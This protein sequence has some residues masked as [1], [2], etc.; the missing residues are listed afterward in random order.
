MLKFPKKN[1][2][3]KIRDSGKI[4]SGSVLAFF[5]VI[6][7]KS[8]RSPSWGLSKTTFRIPSGVYFEI[9]QELFR[10]LWRIFFGIT[11]GFPTAIPPRASFENLQGFVLSS[12]VNSGNRPGIPPGNFW[13]NSLMVS[14]KEF[15]KSRWYCELFWWQSEHLGL[16]IW[17]IAI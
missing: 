17:E 10:I 6:F 5:F 3:Y 7:N 12:F 13:N 14:R 16:R 15:A 4:L 2:R 11:V 1:N 9:L 8:I